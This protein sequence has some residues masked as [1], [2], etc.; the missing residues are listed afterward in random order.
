MFFPAPFLESVRDA[1][2]LAELIG[3][4]VPLKKRGHESVGCCPFHGEKTPSFTVNDQKGFYHCFGCAAHGNC[5]DF[6]MQIENITFPE[7]VEKAAGIAGLALPRPEQSEHLQREAEVKQDIYKVL[8]AAATFFQQQLETS[9]GEHARDYLAKRKVLPATIQKFRIGYGPRASQ[10]LWNHLIKQGFQPALIHRAGLAVEG[11]QVRDR[12]R[13]RL[14]FPITDKSGRVIAFGGRALG[15]F[16]PKYLNSPETEVFHKGKT[17]YNFAN[18][19]R[20]KQGPV[21]LVEGYMDVVSLVQSGFEQAVAPLGT[22]LTAPQ[23]ELL[24][25]MAS[26]PVICFDGDAAGQRAAGRAIE[27]VLPLLKPGHSLNF[28]TL[29]VGEDPDSF[30]Q[31]KGSKAFK[32]ACDN[33]LPLINQIWSNHVQTVPRQTPEQHALF[34]KSLLE[35]CKP[36][37]DTAIRNFYMEEFRQRLQAE[38]YRPADK[39]WKK[40]KTPMQAAPKSRMQPKLIQQK[41][42]VATALQRPDVLPHM[43]ELLMQVEF[44]HQLLNEL[45][46]KI[47]LHFYDNSEKLPL[48]METLRAYLIHEGFEHLMAD[49]L[50]VRI[51]A[52]HLW[53]EHQS[54]EDVLARWQE[55]LEV[56]IGTAKMKEHID[57][58][59]SI[60]QQEMSRGAWERYQQ[61]K[62]MVINKSVS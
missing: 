61:L 1:V 12:F 31:K 10:A 54:A 40:A 18:A 39:S 4:Y 47:L 19:R 3:R 45:R 55:V 22:A 46:N 9:L 17:L 60:L 2:P 27:Q 43:H 42:L 30:V 26:E 37:Q 24:W 38:R 53:D 52:P 62:E 57:S 51:H 8:D 28:L 33:S 34:D 49:V 56:Y 11:E 5:F 6:L 21:L 13:E 29:P 32:E 58:A 15:D 23:I 59:K 16:E 41:I 36:I 14:M 7:A 48:V 50:D 25:T 44:T 20:A 35:T